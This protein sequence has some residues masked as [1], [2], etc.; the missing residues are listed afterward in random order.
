[1]QVIIRSQEARHRKAHNKSWRN[2]NHKNSTKLTKR[3]NRGADVTDCH[4]T[5]AVL[6]NLWHMNKLWQAG[7][8]TLWF[9]FIYYGRFKTVFVIYWEGG[10]GMT[11]TRQRIDALRRS[12]VEHESS[13]ELQL[14]MNSTSVCRSCVHEISGM[15]WVHKCQSGLENEL[16]TF[17]RSKVSTTPGPSHSSQLGNWRREVHYIFL[18]TD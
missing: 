16:I 10:R 6:N 4:P 13:S 1:M 3:G 18:W 11:H 17:W 9:P 7:N 12:G 5:G 15:S 14:M 2:M 8:V